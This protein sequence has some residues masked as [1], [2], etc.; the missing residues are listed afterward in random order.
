VI[1]S[2][3]VKQMQTRRDML[4]LLGLTT[5]AVVIE[6]CIPQSRSGPKTTETLVPGSSEAT[7][8]LKPTMTVTTQPTSTNIPPTETAKPT[9]R[10]TA[11]ATE[12]SL[13]KGNIF[14]DPQSKEDFSKVVEAP[15]PIDNPAE[16]AKWQEEYLKQVNEKLKTYDGTAIDYKTRAFAYGT[17]KLVLDGTDVNVISSYKFKWN[18]MEILAKTF[19]LKD[20][21]DSLVPFSAIY[22]PENSAVGS[23]SYETIKGK[24]EMFLFYEADRFPKMANEPFYSSFFKSVGVET[25][26]DSMC[27]YLRM[28]GEKSVGTDEDRQRF[29]RIPFVLTAMFIY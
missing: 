1:P 28:F 8:T 17:G 3:K 12:V 25:D 18:G 14:F 4:K 10:P 2:Q 24:V 13:V 9:E 6:S 20:D 5:A 7:G 23:H 21:R 27:K 29:S 15:S 19:V 22:P 16:F 26:L 11:T